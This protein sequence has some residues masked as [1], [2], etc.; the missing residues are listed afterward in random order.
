MSNNQFTA[1]GQVQ[2]RKVVCKET[3]SKFSIRLIQNCAE[4][5]T[6]FTR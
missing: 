4:P 3:V 1:P 6:I 5:V 2:T